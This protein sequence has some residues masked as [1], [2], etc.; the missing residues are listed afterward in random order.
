M[1]KTLIVLL[2]LI[3]AFTFVS[4]ASTE[5]PV[6]E[7]EAA[8]VVENTV[9]KEVSSKHDMPEWAI[10]APYDETGELIYGVGFAKMSN[11]K[12]SIKFASAEAKADLANQALLYIQTATQI[13]TEEG[14]ENSYGMLNDQSL[15]SLK[16]ASIQKAEAWIRGY[17]QADLYEATDGTVYVLLSIP[18]DR[19]FD[20]LE[21]AL[22]AKVITAFHE[23]KAATMAHM[24]A[25]DFARNNFKK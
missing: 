20:S 16:D 6:A 21:S 8:P 10:V 5:A 14:G 18:V 17:R 13:Y 22:D 9:V 25:D 24:R 1:K 3:T 23:N 12:N 19:V 2:A 15:Q 7:A 4:C 11:F